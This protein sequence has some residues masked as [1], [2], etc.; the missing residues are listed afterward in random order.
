MTCGGG[1]A[2]TDMMLAQIEQD[3]GKD[4]AVVVADM[5]I[6]HRSDSRKAP[7]KSAYSVALSS[8]NPHLIAAMQYMDDNLEYPVEIDE[9]ADEINIS[10]RQLERLFK[11]HVGIS[12]AQFY[13]EQRVSRAHALLN[14]TAMSVN[15]IAVATGF[16]SSSQLSLRFRK[17]FWAVARRFPQ[18]MGAGEVDGGRFSAVEWCRVCFAGLSHRSFFALR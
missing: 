16:S 17:R 2:A 4:L 11:R 7:Q 9:V 1:S 10:R 8:R 18:K 5:C 15:E 3:H 12:P 6:H 14:E 13:I